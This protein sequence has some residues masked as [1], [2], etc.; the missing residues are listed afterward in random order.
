MKPITCDKIGLGALV[1]V[2]GG[3]INHYYS[4]KYTK[5]TLNDIFIDLC[6]TQTL[7]E[8]LHEVDGN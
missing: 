6:I 1:C 4:A 3:G 2:W 8:K 7:S 5:M